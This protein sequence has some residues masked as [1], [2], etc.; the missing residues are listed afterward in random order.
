MPLDRSLVFVAEDLPKRG[1]RLG[2][3][4]RPLDGASRV[5]VLDAA[6]RIT[7]LRAENMGVAEV[8]SRKIIGG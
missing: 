3:D 6:R 7:L 4:G 1:M 5:E 2:A 8:L